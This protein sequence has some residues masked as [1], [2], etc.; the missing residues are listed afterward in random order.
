MEEVFEEALEKFEEKVDG[1]SK[2]AKRVISA[3]K[4]TKIKVKICVSFFQDRLST[5]A[6]DCI[7]TP[8]PNMFSFLRQGATRVVPGVHPSA[9]AAPL[10]RR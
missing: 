1:S 10:P 3:L 6:T 4:S 5:I 8:P 7:S 2:I 9:S